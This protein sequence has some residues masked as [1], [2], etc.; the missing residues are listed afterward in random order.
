MLI[1]I[2]RPKAC[3][4]IKTPV[5]FIIGSLDEK[6]VLLIKTP[7]IGGLLK[8]SHWLITLS[9]KILVVTGIHD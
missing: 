7:V 1:W 4:V 2:I 3:A 5:K 6:P 8:K 9:I